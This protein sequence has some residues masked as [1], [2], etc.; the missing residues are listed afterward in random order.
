[1]TLYSHISIFWS[2]YWSNY[3]EANN[4]KN[5]NKIHANHD[6]VNALLFMYHPHGEMT[7]GDVKWGANAIATG[8]SSK[9]LEDN[10]WIYYAPITTASG[11]ALALFLFLALA[12]SN[13]VSMNTTLIS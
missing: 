13:V 8:G 2:N 4:Y 11:N 6:K 9:M 5:D 12:T 10:Y 7:N 3:Y 1:M